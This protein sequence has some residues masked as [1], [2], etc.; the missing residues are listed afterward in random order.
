M[1]DLITSNRRANYQCDIFKVICAFIIILRYQW[2]NGRTE[3]SCLAVGGLTR[4]VSF[5]YNK[6]ELISR[7][8]LSKM[9]VKFRALS[10]ITKWNVETD[11]F[12]DVTY[13]SLIYEYSWKN[14]VKIFQMMNHLRCFPQKYKICD[15]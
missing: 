2:T 11:T 3:W 12:K 13:I 4:R 9:A 10:V 6:I 1:L 15:R 5:F 7:K 8:I 14:R